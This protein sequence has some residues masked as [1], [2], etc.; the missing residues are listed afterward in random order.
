MHCVISQ[1]RYE[2]HFFNC[3]KFF[4]CSHPFVLIFTVQ[5]MSELSRVFNEEAVTWMPSLSFPEFLIAFGMRLWENQPSMYKLFRQYNDNSE[6][7]LVFVKQSWYWQ[8][9]QII[10]KALI[11]ALCSRQLGVQWLRCCATNRKVAGSIPDGVIGIFH[12]HNPSD[13]TT[14]LGSTQPLT[15]MSTRRISGG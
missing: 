5:D 10:C 13:R 2:L 1:K 6:F 4:L 9:L 11:D 14:A 8:L 12:S 15:E 3:L 7:F